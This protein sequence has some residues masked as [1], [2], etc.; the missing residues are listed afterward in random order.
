MPQALPLILVAATVASV[1]VSAYGISQQTKAAKDSANASADVARQEQQAE[2]VR[3]Q[4]M[5]ADARRKQLEN[6]RQMQRARAMSLSSATNQGAIYGTG[7]QGGYGQISGQG[8]F[9]AQ[10]IDQSLSTGE[11][12]FGINSNISQD[13]VNMAG[14]SANAAMGAG[15]TSLGG[16]IL[17]ASSSLGRLSGGFGSSTKSGD[18]ILPPPS[19]DKSWYGS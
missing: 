13:R 5:E 11:Q 4:A 18:G 16:S 19:L 8:N 17:T 6:L 15:L 9:N 14:Y 7:L 2:A 10:G 3:Q 1:G 12:L